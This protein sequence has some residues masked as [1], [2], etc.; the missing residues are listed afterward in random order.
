[1]EEGRW[2]IGIFEGLII[3]F[4]LQRVDLKL[5]IIKLLKTS[6][7]MKILAIVTIYTSKI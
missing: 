3:R 7:V 2:E 5:L 1:M 6:E 4:N